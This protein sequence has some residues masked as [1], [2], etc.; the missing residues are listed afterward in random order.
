MQTDRSTWIAAMIDDFVASS[1]ENTLNAPTGEKAFDPPLVGFSSGSDP[2]YD[3]Y[4]HTSAIF[5]CVPSTFLTG[6]FRNC[7]SFARHVDGDQLGA[8]RYPAHPQRSVHRD[9]TAVRAMGLRQTS[10]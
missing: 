5:I 4:V 2:L 1:R 8:P 10:W 7:A 6:R 9:E 3:D